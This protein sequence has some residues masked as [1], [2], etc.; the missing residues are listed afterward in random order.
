M[1]QRDYAAR[2]GSKKK[3]STKKSLLLAIATGVIVAFVLGL[4][5]LKEKAPEPVKQ[6]TPSVV[7]EEKDKHKSQ[8]PSKLEETFS[9]IKELEN[10][11]ITNSQPVQLSETQKAELKRLQEEEQARQAA[12]EKLK[13]TESTNITMAPN[14]GAQVVDAEL[15]DVGATEPAVNDEAKLKAEQERTVA[16]QKKLADQRK[17]EEE[18]K[19]AEQKKEESKKAN[20]AKS[21]GKFGLQCGAFNDRAKAE[22]L[23]ARL[24]MAGLNARIT[25]SGKWNRVLIG[26]IGDR[27]AAVSAQQQASAI[28]GCVVIGM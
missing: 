13:Q 22:S 14:A 8:L 26:P 16:E 4:Y 23:Q 11:S 27:P 10:R 3:K 2:S 7:S 19:L 20:A 5:L 15:T 9:Y 17:K 1:A 18:R 25:E 24:A 12:L 21:A 28:A 6:N